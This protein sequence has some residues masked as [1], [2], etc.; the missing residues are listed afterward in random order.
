MAKTKMQTS[1]VFS[2]DRLYR[3]SLTRR[4]GP[5]EAVNFVMLNPSTADEEDDDATIRRCLGYARSW[6]YDAL[7]VTNLYAWR[8]TDPKVLARAE[9]PIGPDN[10][11]H[12]RDAAETSDIAVCAWGNHADAARAAAVRQILRDVGADAYMLKLTKAGRPS[13]PLRLPANLK[14]TPF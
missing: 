13:H 10:D 1:A 6:G 9:T 14:P 8:A 5:G 3:Y 7:V 11:D 4:W 2:K 12:I